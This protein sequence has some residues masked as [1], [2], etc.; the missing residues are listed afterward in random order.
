MQCNATEGQTCL[1][2]LQPQIMSRISTK[3]NTDLVAS[4][5]FHPVDVRAGG[6]IVPEVDC[7]AYACSVRAP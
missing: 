2:D 1:L 5:V 3:A 7:N 6:R 4:D